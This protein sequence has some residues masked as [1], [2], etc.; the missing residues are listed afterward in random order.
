MS[1]FSSAVGF[2]TGAVNFGTALGVI[3]EAGNAGLNENLFIT[4]QDKENG[5]SV[6]AR[7]ISYSISNQADWVNKFEGMDGDSKVPLMSALLQGGAY[8][9]DIEVLKELTAKTLITKAQSIQVWTGLQPQSISLELEFKATVDPVLEVEQPIQKLVRM[10][11]PALK[12][13]SI[14][15]ID[16]VFSSVKAL[17]ASGANAQSVKTAV[18]PLGD[19][20]SDIAITFFRKRFNSTYRI[21]GLE[22]SV[23]EVRIDAVGNRIYQIVSLTLGSTTGI[24]K[25]DVEP[26]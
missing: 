23:D 5:T 24:M 16:A 3:G 2:V 20:P 10:M 15:T 18:A 1:L 6:K 26:V 17:L 13:T 8:S 14:D 7:I 9:K 11:S 19:V 22:E 12:D 21:E 4:L 25:S